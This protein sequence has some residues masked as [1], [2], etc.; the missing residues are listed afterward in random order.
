M[1]ESGRETA[2]SARPRQDKEQ[3]VVS[4][5]TRSSKVSAKVEVQLSLAEGGRIT[6]A[7]AYYKARPESDSRAR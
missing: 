1:G 6:S 3:K 5:D 2:G 4:L 7:K